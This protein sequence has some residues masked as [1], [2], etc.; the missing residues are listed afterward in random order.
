MNAREAVVTLHFV[1]NRLL[2]SSAPFRCYRPSYELFEK[3]SLAL[4]RLFETA[5]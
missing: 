2:R 4:K 1:G 5:K 3:H